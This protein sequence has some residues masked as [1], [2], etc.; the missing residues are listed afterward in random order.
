M[1]PD[2]YLYQNYGL[3]RLATLTLGQRL[4]SATP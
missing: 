1:L 3:V 2:T 4:L